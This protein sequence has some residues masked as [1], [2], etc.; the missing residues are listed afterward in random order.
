MT[1]AAIGGRPSLADAQAK[2]SVRFAVRKS[3]IGEVERQMENEDLDRWTERQRKNE[4]N[5][6]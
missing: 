1:M 3:R 5:D 4:E 6:R 2:R